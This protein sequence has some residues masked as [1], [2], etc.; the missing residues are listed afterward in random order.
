MIQKKEKMKRTSHDRQNDSSQQQQ[1]HPS[2]GMHAYLNQKG[3]GILT[4]TCLYR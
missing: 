1:R 2:S 4:S 3:V